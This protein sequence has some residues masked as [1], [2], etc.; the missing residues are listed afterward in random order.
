MHATFLAMHSGYSTS[1]VHV[2]ATCACLLCAEALD[3]NH[4]C[5]ACV[6][7]CFV[8]LHHVQFKVAMPRHI[9]LCSACIM[10]VPCLQGLEA[11]ELDAELLEPS[12]PVPAAKVHL[13]ALHAA[14]T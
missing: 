9:C 10:K 7:M 4:S 11:E 12:A 8:F 3:V 14:V 1:L 2:Y 6:C 5:S 13:L